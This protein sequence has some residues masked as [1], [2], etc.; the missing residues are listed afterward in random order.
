M[1]YTYVLLDKY[2]HFYI[3]Q[4]DNLKRRIFEHKNAKVY[5]TKSKL[6]VDLIY[7]E[8][9]LNK[10]DS[11]KREMYLKSGPG[12]RYLKKR[13]FNNLIDYKPRAS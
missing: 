2:R 5:S 6:P 8:S 13:L 1:F 9:C 7:Y 11:I 3:G 4:T 12:K 10:Y